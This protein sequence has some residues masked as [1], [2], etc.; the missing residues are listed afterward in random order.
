MIVG[1]GFCA[2]NAL[3]SKWRMRSF[4]FGVVVRMEML[5]L[6]PGR[7]CF[8]LLGEECCK[9]GLSVKCDDEMTVQEF[10]RCW[11]FFGTRIFFSCRKNSEKEEK[12][13]FSLGSEQDGCHGAHI[14]ILS[15]RIGCRQHFCSSVVVPLQWRWG[16][17]QFV[18]NIFVIIRTLT[19]SKRKDKDRLVYFPCACSLAYCLSFVALVVIFAS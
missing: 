14:G 12:I 9:C 10:M 11:F 19:T 7:D 4:S 1:L 6:Q 13:F 2:G 8:F 18:K 15:S 3:Q 16:T 17:E 5:K